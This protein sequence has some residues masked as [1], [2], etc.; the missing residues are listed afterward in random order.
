MPEK[1]EQQSNFEEQLFAEQKKVEQPKIDEILNCPYCEDAGAC[2]FCERGR[3][4]LADNAKKPR[5]V[6]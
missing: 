6:A 5:K 2:T 1:F 3:Q 4:W